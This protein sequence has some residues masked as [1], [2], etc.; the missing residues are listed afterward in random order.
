M[1]NRKLTEEEMWDQS[2]MKNLEVYLAYCHNEL[3]YG[4]EVKNAIEGLNRAVKLKQ[5]K[6]SQRSLAYL[7][8]QACPD[9]KQREILLS[10]L[11]QTMFPGLGVKKITAAAS[12]DDN[13]QS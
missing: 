6:Q 10:T 3:A 13:S 5:I 2:L 1:A 9:K 12:E 7:I 11:S 4:Q 8:I